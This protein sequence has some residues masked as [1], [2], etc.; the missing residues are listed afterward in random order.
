MP[1]NV[2]LLTLSHRPFDLISGNADTSAISHI[3]TRQLAYWWRDKQW[4]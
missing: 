3:R 4:C 1:H 2:Y